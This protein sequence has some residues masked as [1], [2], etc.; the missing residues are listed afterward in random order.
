MNPILVYKIVAAAG[1]LSGIGGTLYGLDQHKKRYE[2]KERFNKDRKELGNKVE[3]LL[4]EISDLNSE[5]KKKNQQIK[6]LASRISELKME[7]KALRKIGEISEIG[8]EKS[9]NFKD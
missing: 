2:E 7:N 9:L 5:F 6:D 1:T 4:E 3:S 8:G